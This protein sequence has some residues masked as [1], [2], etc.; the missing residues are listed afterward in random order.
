MA[1][2]EKGPECEPPLWKEC[3]R[4]DKAYITCSDSI[5]SPTASHGFLSWSVDRSCCPCGYPVMSFVNGSQHRLLASCWLSSRR[6]QPHGKSGAWVAEW[7]EC[8]LCPRSH[9]GLHF[10]LL[11]PHQSLPTSAIVPS[12][13]LTSVILDFDVCFLSLQTCK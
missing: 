13:L 11:V 3:T 2:P 8:V 9:S 1:Q 5:R 12:F 4:V 10:S 6:G 7:E